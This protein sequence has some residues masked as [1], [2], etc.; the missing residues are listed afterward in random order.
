MILKEFVARARFGVG[1]T[2][3]PPSAALVLLPVQFIGLSASQQC[4]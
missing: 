2:E 3:L 4:R 1:T